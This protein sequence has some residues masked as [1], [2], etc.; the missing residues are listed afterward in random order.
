[1]APRAA[2]SPTPHTGSD[3]RTNPQG[4]S[5]QPYPAHPSAPLALR[6]PSAGFLSS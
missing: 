4:L 1:M 3:A 6:S 5:P 2:A